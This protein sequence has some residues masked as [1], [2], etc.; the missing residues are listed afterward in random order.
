MIKLVEKYKI[1][2]NTPVG[3]QNGELTFMINKNSLSGTITGHNIKS[4]FYNGKISNNNFEF[5]GMLTKGIFNI[6]YL[7]K[8]TLDK[9]GI[10]GYV[11]TKYGTFSIKGNKA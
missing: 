3:I 8:G 9:N 6:S 2:L 11:K 4:S 5:Y 10:T 1:S 7:A